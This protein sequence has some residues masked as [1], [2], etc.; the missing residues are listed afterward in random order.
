MV[1]NNL[2]LACDQDTGGGMVRVRRWLRPF[3]W[4][5]KNVVTRVPSEKYVTR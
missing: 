3:R 5:P 1:D 4:P 2:L